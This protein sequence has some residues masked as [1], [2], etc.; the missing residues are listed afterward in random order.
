[1]T[2][3]RDNRYW[4]DY[5]RAINIVNIGD[6][7]TIYAYDHEQRYITVLIKLGYL[8]RYIYPNRYHMGNEYKKLKDIPED[9]RWMEALRLSKTIPVEKKGRKK[10]SFFNNVV[11]QLNRMDIN[12]VFQR[13]VLKS[14]R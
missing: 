14:T 12:H 11:E 10:Y 6:I 7:K 2:E 9:L 1:M 4:I 3:R 5:R 8:E 13:S